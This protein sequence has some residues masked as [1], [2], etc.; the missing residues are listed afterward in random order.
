MKHSINKQKLK[1]LN[2]MINRCKLLYMEDSKKY[3]INIDI[4][5]SKP[6]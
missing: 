3:N 1:E 5:N 2:E 6:C 4:P